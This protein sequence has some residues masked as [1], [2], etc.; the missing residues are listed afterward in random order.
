M[1]R[2]LA[3]A[4]AWAVV[5]GGTAAPTSAVTFSRTFE[6]LRIRF[7]STQIA[8]DTSVRSEWGF[9]ALVEADEARLLFDTGYLPD[10]VTTNATSLHVDLRGIHDIVLSHWHGDH[11]G[12]IETV[13]KAVGG[14][15]RLHVH[16]AIFDAKFRRDA[17]DRQVNTLGARR[18]GIE[19]AHGTFRQSSD[20]HEILPGMVLTGSIPRLR[21]NDQKLP[22]FY[23]VATGET[24]PVPDEQ[25]LVIN[26]RDGLVVLTGCGHAGTVNTVAYV[27]S[28]FPNRPIVS[29][30][31]GFHWYAS[32]EGEI[33]EAGQRLKELG[34]ERLMGAHCT[35]VE[36]MFT[37]RQHGWSRQT[38]LVGAVGRDFILHSTSSS[39]GADGV[40]AAVD[41]R[42]E[43]VCHGRTVVKRS[44]S[45]GFEKR[46]EPARF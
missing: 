25:A 27:R 8:A 28:L 26:T 3:A 37:L 38:A 13:L 16:P 19:A 32:P 5:V 42:G 21:P 40:S 24:D 44:K 30:V 12:G 6:N 39:P 35:L 17:P 41:A 15:A 29:V 9:G 2:A 22:D 20:A 23:V 10:T 46:P 43:P 31:G 11:T 45:E 18:A 7:L 33:V 14:D 36:P 4:V 1:M 34:V